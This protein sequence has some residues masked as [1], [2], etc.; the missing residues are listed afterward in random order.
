[1]LLSGLYFFITF[2]IKPYQF[3]TPIIQ[4]FG[5]EYA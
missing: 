5:I 4:P 1:M 3:L 2:Y